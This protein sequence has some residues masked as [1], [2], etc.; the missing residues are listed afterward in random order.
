M[1]TATW[2]KNELEDHGVTFEELHHRDAFSAQD[3]A[4]REHISGHR[5]AKVVVVMADDR[6]VV[7]VLPASRR[8][9][10]DRV[11][12]ILGTGFVRLATQHEI[13]DYFP[14]CEAGALPPFRHWEGV[15]VLM[16]GYLHV[17]GDIVFQAGT[18]RDAV[19]MNF[20]D[21]FE[22]VLPRVE[23]FSERN[24]GRPPYRE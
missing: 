8:V 15:D 6:P 3:I 17:T 22:L 1:A 14:D 7:L 18:H 16:D 21:W 24:H 19:R 13:E 5:V 20:G 2:I 12:D 4:R 9:V 11:K 23:M 10:L